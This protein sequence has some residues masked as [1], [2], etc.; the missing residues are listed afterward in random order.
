M[1][2]MVPA[3]TSEQLQQFLVDCPWEANGL[4]RRRLD[5]LVA[6]GHTDA[7]TGV[8]CIDDTGLLQQGKHS[9][10][11]KRQYCGGL[12]S[13]LPSPHRTQSARYCSR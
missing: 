4:E 13:D 1:A 2:E 9:V 3:A 11:V 8:L 7:G 5:V 10:G 12:S 6:E